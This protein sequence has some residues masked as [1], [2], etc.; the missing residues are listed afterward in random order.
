MKLFNANLEVSIDASA[1]GNI[2]CNTL[3]SNFDI[4][5][6]DLQALSIYGGAAIQ[7]QQ[8]IDNA[9]AAAALTAHHWVL[10]MKIY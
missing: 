7:I 4:Q 3:I 5:C 2:T 10:V 6:G 1:F 8:N 9:I